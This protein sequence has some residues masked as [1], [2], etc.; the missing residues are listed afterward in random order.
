MNKNKFKKIAAL[1]C[2]AALTGVLAF[3]LTACGDNNDNTGDG[4]DGT[5]TTQ[6]ALQLNKTSLTVKVGASDTVQV[7]SATT[8]G[9]TWS[10]SDPTVATVKAGGN[11][12]KVCTV[13]GLKE[14]TATVTAKAGDYEITCSVTVTA[15][16]DVGGNDDLGD[17][18]DIPFNANQIDGWSYWSAD[19]VGE[20]DISISKMCVYEAGE[21]TEV[22]VTYTANG[23]PSDALQLRLNNK[24]SGVVH[25]LSL[26]VVS[27]VEGKTIVV[28]GQEVELTEGENSVEVKG[29]TNQAISIQ[30]GYGAKWDPTF[31]TGSNLEFVF[32]DI[33]ITSTAEQLSTPSFT[34]DSATKKITITDSNTSSKV[35]SYQLGLFESATATSP[36]ATVTVTNGGTVDLTGVSGGKYVAKIRAVGANNNI[37]N[38]EWSE[39]SQEITVEGN[40][41]SITPESTDGWYYWTD[42]SVGENNYIDE[43]NVIHIFNLNAPQNPYSFQLKKD[44][45]GK[46]IT[47]I[48]LTVHAAQGGYIAFG[49]ADNG[50]TQEVEVAANTDVPIDLTGLNYTGTFVIC[51]ANNVSNWANPPA[52]LAPLGGDITLSITEIT[53]K[54]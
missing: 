44:L 45:N 39:G 4:G 9:I 42:G 32:K 43:N 8:T 52:P 29:F 49:T 12:G 25:D 2:T 3:S 50:S 10:S 23:G 20:S 24:Y 40:N 14:G 37:I 48:K 16:G 13:T 54:S 35:G 27:P 18:V 26:T 46:T 47:G 53:Y 15:A 41:V 5:N 51:F 11:G 1:A 31:I 30:F 38:S 19:S 28:N 17:P 7:T 34:Y 33:V 6:G 22:H 21:K 36:K